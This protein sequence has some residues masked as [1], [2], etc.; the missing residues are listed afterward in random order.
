MLPTL[1][2]YMREMV[3]NQSL[4]REIYVANQKQLTK[5]KNKIMNDKKYYGNSP[6]YQ[7][8]WYK[9]GAQ[10]FNK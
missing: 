7:K 8:L 10:G 9:T 2:Q 4:Y 6:E 5:E 3:A 1:P